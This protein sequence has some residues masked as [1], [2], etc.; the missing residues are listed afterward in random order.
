M[1]KWKVLQKEMFD[2][3]ALV[4]ELKTDWKTVL[5]PIAKKHNDELKAFF[6]KEQYKLQD[7]TE[8]LPPRNLI[9]NAFDQFDVADLKVVILGQDVYPTKGDGMGLC[10]SSPSSRKIPPSLRNIFKEL[11][12]EYGTQRKNTDLTDWAR[13]GVLMLNTALTVRE[14]SAGSHI[15]IWKDF[16]MD[17]IKHITQTTENLVY[18]LWGEHAIRHSQHVDENKNCILRHSHPSPLA[19]RPFTGCNHF[20]ECNNAL[21]SYGKDPIKWV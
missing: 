19:R 9:L 1:C 13:Q 5:L 10:F 2:I 8:I 4:K 7:V 16:T 18:L 3:T 12:R 6:E 11:E 21:I 20:V 17:V 14:G 15:K